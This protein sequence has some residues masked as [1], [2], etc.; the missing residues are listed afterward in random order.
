MFEFPFKLRDTIKSPDCE[1]CKI[2]QNEQSVCFGSMTNFNTICSCQ[3]TGSKWY[4]CLNTKLT[5]LERTFEL[6]RILYFSKYDSDI[7]DG[8][9]IPATESI[10]D[11]F[12]ACGTISNTK[13]KNATI[14]AL[15][16][17]MSNN[18][19]KELC[20]GAKQSKS[21]KGKGLYPEEISNILNTI[22]NNNK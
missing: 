12:N 5:E 19:I 13:F 1:P 10:N 14:Y 6:F 3:N 21:K 16:M 7:G 8:F 17:L 15:L 20:G 18:K 22:A 4:I 2:K 9:D 11:Y